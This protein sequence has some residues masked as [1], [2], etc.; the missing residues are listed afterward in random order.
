MIHLPSKFL[1]DGAD[2]SGLMTPS[3]ELH[4]EGCSLWGLPG[5]HNVSVADRPRQGS[6]MDISILS[7]LVLCL[8]FIS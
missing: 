1:E 2:A 7:P 8:Y 4:S 5:Y 3:G 6:L